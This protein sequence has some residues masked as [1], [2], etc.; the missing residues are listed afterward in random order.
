MEKWKERVRKQTTTKHAGV[1]R[2]LGKRDT[3]DITDAGGKGV[4]TLVCEIA[5]FRQ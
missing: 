5:N 2:D 4:F 1:I 3:R